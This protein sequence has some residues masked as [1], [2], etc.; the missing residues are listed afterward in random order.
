MS[1]TIEAINAAIEKSNEKE[2]WIS[3]WVTEEESDAIAV[4]KETMERLEAITNHLPG[5]D[6]KNWVERLAD[7]DRSIVLFFSADMT[8]DPLDRLS[9]IFTIAAP[10]DVVVKSLAHQ[11]FVLMAATEYDFAKR[12]QF[13]MAASIL[14]GKDTLP[15]VHT[16][17]MMARANGIGPQ[18]P[19][20]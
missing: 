5:Y 6:D 9:Y 8:G 18:Y 20:F 16:I 15:R 13:A 11:Y 12:H 2:G 17:Y 14:S 19:V 3:R 1:R 7:D 10:Y 4:L